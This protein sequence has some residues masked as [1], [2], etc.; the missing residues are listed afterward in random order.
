VD[1][2]DRRNF[3]L[4]GGVVLGVLAAEGCVISNATAS[5][6]ALAAASPTSGSQVVSFGW[7]VCNLHGNGANAFF[8]V[9]TNMILQT[10]CT[11]I[12]ASILKPS[13]AGFA[14]ILC[15]GGVSR[16]SSPA[17]NNVAPAYVNF[18]ASTNFGSVATDNP[19]GLSV[20]MDGNMLQDQFLAVILKTWVP[21]DGA[22]S[23]TARHCVV[24]PSLALSSGDYLVF[25]M[26]HVGVSVDC[27]MQVVLTYSL[28]S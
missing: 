3:L 26:D 4:G 14:E 7:E 23:A 24:S 2:R 10:V 18:P 12:S 22:G 8:P 20:I 17:F 25:H 15:V 28:S 19:N 1:L 11:D 6:T 16:Q 27:E 5:A 21:A 9:Q 13:A